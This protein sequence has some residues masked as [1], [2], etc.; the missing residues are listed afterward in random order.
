M[1]A[2]GLISR[3][4]AFAADWRKTSGGSASSGG[5]FNE[6]PKPP[7]SVDRLDGDGSPDFEF[8][9]SCRP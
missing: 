7:N 2:L 6:G 1:A 9:A 8:L 3:A 5:Y 4:P